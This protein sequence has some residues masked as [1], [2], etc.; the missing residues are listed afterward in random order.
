M[1][2]TNSLPSPD[3]EIVAL[4]RRIDTQFPVGRFVAF[5]SGEVI[6]DADTHREL[7]EKLGAMGKSP[8]DM[9]ILQAGVEYPESA[10]ILLSGSC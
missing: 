7:A 6:A 10:I 3:P 1:S 8:H 4:K 2:E 5:Q 9:L